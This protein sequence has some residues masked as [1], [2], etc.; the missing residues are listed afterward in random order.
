MIPVT[1]SMEPPSG[2]MSPY[3]N[4]VGQFA[5]HE[6]DLLVSGSGVEPGPEEWPF[7]CL[8]LEHR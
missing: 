8:D 4:S 7:P 3:V 6:L 5:P 2:L 1:W